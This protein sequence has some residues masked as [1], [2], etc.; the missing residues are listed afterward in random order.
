[1]KY[2]LLSALLASTAAALPHLEP[3][4]ARY[5]GYKVLR[6]DTGDR[7]EEVKQLLADFDYEEWSHDVSKH[8]D[9]SLPADQAR[10]LKGLGAVFEEMHSDLGRDI[11]DEGRAC[12]YKGMGF[13]VL[14]SFFTEVGVVELM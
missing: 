9:F 8:I 4:A 3:R 14:S 12:G 2:T 7:L 11:A 10:K 6:M 1:M 5:E 13:E